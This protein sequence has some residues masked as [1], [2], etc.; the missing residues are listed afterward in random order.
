MRLRRRNVT[1]KRA[2]NT[3]PLPRSIWLT[4]ALVVSSPTDSRMVET[5][6]KAMG[7]ASSRMPLTPGPCALAV[8]GTVSLVTDNEHEH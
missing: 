7:T 2:E 8:A 3:M 4:E 6:S 1:A 5:R